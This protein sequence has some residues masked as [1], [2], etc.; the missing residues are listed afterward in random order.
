MSLDALESRFESPSFDGGA[1]AMTQAAP[2]AATA[3]R[4]THAAS[5]GTLILIC[6]ALRVWTSAHGR[7]EGVQRS[8][9]AFLS[10]KG[11]GVLAPVLDGLFAACEHALARPL[12]PGCGCDLSADESWIAGP[13]GLARRD[14]SGWT[15]RDPHRAALLDGAA[16]SAAI[17]VRMALAPAAERH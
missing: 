10:P 1:A 15:I 14:A 7:G 9:Y 16:R 6:K 11:L 4:E 2:Q 12:R 3:A 13:I 17:M 5:F 8:L